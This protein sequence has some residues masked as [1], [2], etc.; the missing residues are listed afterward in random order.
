MKASH[1]NNLVDQVRSD[2]FTL[3]EVVI[4]VAISSVLM[5]GLLSTFDWQNRVY[6]LEQAE[7]LAT[8]SA[9]VALNNMTFSLTQGSN[10]LQS[11]TINGV[12]YTT[13]GTTVVIQIPSYDSSGVLIANTYDHVVYTLSGSNL[14]QVVELGAN[15][16]RPLVNKRLSDKV[17]SFTLSYNN[18]DPTLASQ[19][20]IDLT[21]RAYYHSDKSASVHLIETVFLRN[22]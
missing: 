7:V 15:S 13:G 5:L 8:G 4:V 1:K 18:N 3:I 10:I 16:D 2:G 22:K 20:T 6:N 11:R 17:E 9:R 14:E 19:V 12:N 21:T